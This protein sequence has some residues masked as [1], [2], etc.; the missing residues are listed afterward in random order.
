MEEP[1]HLSKKERRELR[2][3]GQLPN[4]PSTGRKKLSRKLIIWGSTLVG[5]AV[6]VWGLMYLAESQTNTNNS[7]STVEAVSANDHV[8]GDRNA[9][10][11]LIEYSDFQCPACG[12]YEPLV[13]Q[14]SETFNERL[15]VVYRHYPLTAIHAN[16][17]PAA[18]ASEAADN[19][20]AFWPFHDLL[21][22][23]QRDWSSLPNTKRTFLDYAQEL[24][25]NTEQF[26]RDMESNEAKD[27]VDDHLARGTRAKVN[28]TPTFFLNGQKI[29]NPRTLDAFKQLIEDAIANRPANQNANSSAEQIH[30]HADFRMAVNGQAIDF[31]AD[32][33]QSTKDQELNP[34]IHFHDGKGDLFHVHADNQTLNDLLTS[35][36]MELTAACVKLDTGD[37]QCSPAPKLYVNGQLNDQF[38]AYVPKDLDRIVILGGTL[39]DAQAAEQLGAVS[40]QACIYSEKCPERGSPPTEECV[41][42][43]GTDCET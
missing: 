4:Q 6:L 38:G 32:K 7:N 27:T 43:L 21:F 22:D 14:L 33:Y 13:Q 29:Q 11:I 2:R 35:F 31:T 5:L 16:A 25:L 8:R 30:L 19:Q 28:G 24:G 1:R 18:I 39:S 12:S 3:A 20:D 36:G 23:R 17:E 41:G 15:A 26:E 34:R 37:P 10:A 40:D 9:P 42:G